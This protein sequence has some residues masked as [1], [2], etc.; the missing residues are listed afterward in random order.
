MEFF[1]TDRTLIFI[2]FFMTVPTKEE[3]VNILKKLERESTLTE[4]DGAYAISSNWM[5]KYK[6]YIGFDRIEAANIEIDKIEN[7]DIYNEDSLTKLDSRKREIFDYQI[8]D[9]KEWD[10]LYGWYG[11]DYTI[12]L[13]VVTDQK[14]K[15][16]QAIVNIITAN[17]T[18]G[19]EKKPISFHRYMLVKEL[20]D[21]ARKLFS[22]PDDKEIAL[23]DYFNN[24]IQA[25]MTPEHTIST[26]NI[27]NGQN[28]VIDFK[29]ENGNWKYQKNIHIEPLKTDKPAT[30]A[31][32]TAADAKKEDSSSD[33][34]PIVRIP[35]RSSNSYYSRSYDEPGEP[36]CHGF[37]NLGNTCYFNSGTQC[38]MHSMP[39]MKHFLDGSWEQWINLENKLGSRGNLVRAFNSVAQKMWSPSTSGAIRPSELKSAVG[40]FNSRFSGYEQHDSHEL[41]LFMLDGIHEDLNRCKNKPQVE[42][43]I[44]DGTNDEET[45]IESWKRCKLRNDSIIVDHFYGL[46][47]SKLICPNCNKT[48]VVFDP[49]LTVE[50]PLAKEN[51][52]KLNVHFV[53]F[54]ICKK[55]TEM[56][57][58]IK[59]SEVNSIKA[60]SEAVS[61]NL[62]R[63]VIVC[64]GYI[65]P[66]SQ[67]LSLGFPESYLERSSIAV[68]I[69]IPNPQK[70]YVPVYF[71]GKVGSEY[72]TTFYTQKSV[73]PPILIELDSPELEE[74]KM[75]EAVL[76]AIKPLLENKSEIELSETAQKILSRIDVESSANTELSVKFQNV[77]AVSKLFKCVSKGSIQI[78]ADLS[79]VD[80]KLIVS[81]TQP[82][83]YY[84][85]KDASANKI[86]LDDCFKLFSTFDTLDEQNQW[87]C[88][89]C[90]EFV[91]AQ[92]KMDIWRAP[93]ILV[94]HLKRFSGEGYYVKKDSSLVDFP[95]Q[96]DMAPYILEK[97][98][99]S[100]KY[101]LFAVSEHMGSMGGGHYIAHAVVKEKWYKFDDSSCSSS[102]YEDAKS[103][104]AY[105]LFYQRI[106][107]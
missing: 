7:A 88:P 95:E 3:Q 79:K 102:S 60:I 54:G 84:T 16:T 87:H 33:E 15:K 8:I 74:E 46:L 49:F 38:L 89:H 13:T 22:I 66:D 53:P 81:T 75:K 96:L 63:N 26:Y 29:D 83:P 91:C 103:P 69:E 70:F 97:T 23:I 92:K 104:L 101:K 85:R 58:A 42:S 47:R 24:V 25:V 40:G 55:W 48:T 106:D 9:K 14:T 36:G 93:E 2:F 10:T 28:I 4:E 39:L 62:G 68:C 98:D 45:A 43:V 34:E 6:S 77:D 67:K 57:I 37:N 35:V 73:A 51:E 31:T 90:K 107:N 12:K 11:A 94:I 21:K 82:N 50:L 56:T 44:G 52:K 99:M 17:V 5:R 65:S 20:L 86:A 19:T 64:P 78:D 80:L 61:K 72:N 27:Q 59:Q 100:T 18:Y 1:L 105:V 30:Q 76:E 41:I 32:A 71:F